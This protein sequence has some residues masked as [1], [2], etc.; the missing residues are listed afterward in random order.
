MPFRW[1]GSHSTGIRTGNCQLGANYR[2][3][4]NLHSV[5]LST[6]RQSFCKQTAYNLRLTRLIKGEDKP[7]QN[8]QVSIFVRTKNSHLE[9]P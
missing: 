6:H 5:S 8:V 9:T 4:L 1:E 3:I 7:L 2:Y